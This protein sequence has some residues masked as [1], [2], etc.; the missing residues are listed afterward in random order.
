[1]PFLHGLSDPVVSHARE[2]WSCNKGNILVKE[3]HTFGAEKHVKDIN[4]VLNTC[5]ILRRDRARR[6]WNTDNN[7]LGS[8]NKLYSDSNLPLKR[9]AHIW[10]NFPDTQSNLRW[11]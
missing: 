6:S 5:A 10:R 4:H 7:P 1:M 11:D 3:N 2:L 9:D 8:S